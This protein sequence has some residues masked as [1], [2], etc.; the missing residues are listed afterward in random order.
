M[1]FSFEEINGNG[2]SLAIEMNDFSY[3]QINHLP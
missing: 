1:D 3:K 2:K